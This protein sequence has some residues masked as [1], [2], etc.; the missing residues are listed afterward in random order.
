M[1]WGCGNL[2]FVN[3]VYIWPFTTMSTVSPNWERLPLWSRWPFC[4]SVKA[5]STG[6]GFLLALSPSSELS[7]SIRTKPAAALKMWVKCEFF[8]IFGKVGY[9]VHLSQGPWILG[10]NNV[11]L[12]LYNWNYIL[13]NLANI[14]KCT[15]ICCRPEE[16]DYYHVVL[17]YFYTM[18]EHMNSPK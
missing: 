8:F 2:N 18:R 13:E 7:G 11:T 3:T 12:I 5:W 4:L 17:D 9:W 6:S 16:Y 1:S 15:W 10:L 14:L